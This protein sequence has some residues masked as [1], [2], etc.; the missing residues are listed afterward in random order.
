MTF[1]RKSCL[2]ALT[3]VC[4]SLSAKGDGTPVTIPGG[5]DLVVSINVRKLLDSGLFKKYGS[6]V[7]AKGL[8]SPD[9]K[10]ILD[11]TGIDPLK[12]I[13]S[14]VVASPVEMTS[15]KGVIIIKGKFDESKIKTFAEA[16]SK[17]DG[18]F[19]FKTSKE[20]ALTFHEIIPAQMPDPIYA[21][22]TDRST[23][24]LGGEKDYLQ[25]FASGKTEKLSGKLSTLLGKLKG[26]EG[27]SAVAVMTEDL[28]K[29]LGTVPGFETIGPKIESGLVTLNVTDGV[30]LKVDVECRRRQNRRRD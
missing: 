19:K 2:V 29:M 15:K 17:K 30:D 16:A 13:E 24:L 14:I 9:A 27:V 18:A 25:T 21:T 12:D 23:I 1:L 8:T 4:M 7:V 10:G 6:D 28:K 26:T 22:F 20:G 5:V 3:L 11:A